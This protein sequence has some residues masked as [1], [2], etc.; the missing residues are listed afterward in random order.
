M[1]VSSRIPL[2]FERDLVYRG[3]LRPDTSVFPTMTW[4]REWREANFK[5]TSNPTIPQS[6]VINLEGVVTSAEALHDFLVPLGEGIRDGAYGPSALFI[7]SSSPALR[8]MLTGLA[9][10]HRFPLFL[11]ESVES[12]LVDAVPVGPLTPA[13]RAVLGYLTS[14]GGVATSAQLANAE[15]LELAA[16]GN[17][18]ASTHDKSYVAKIER[19]R[20]QGNQF[21]DLR[22]AFGPRHGA[23]FTPLPST[24]DFDR[25][26]PAQIQALVD[27]TARAQN[28]DPAEVLAD[29]W[30]LYIS[31]DYDAEA[32]DFRKVGEMLA[33]HDREGVREYL[34]GDS[35]SSAQGSPRS[36]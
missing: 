18:L 26:D 7:V 14:S 17:R 34:R 5:P 22:V 1:P 35:S 13:D 6:W 27:E 10:R 12:A 21:I 29:V 4:L 8:E 11:L 25:G 9:E 28:R 20:K 3:R 30:R 2:A 16:A 23:S 36:E 19:P 32:A 31:R 33:R 15:G 24:P